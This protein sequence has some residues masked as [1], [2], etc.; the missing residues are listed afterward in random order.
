MNTCHILLVDDEEFVRDCI[1]TAL[2]RAGFHVTAVE[3]GTEA[4][5]ILE[6][7]HMGAS[8]FDLLITDMNMPRLTG[9]AL[10]DQLRTN[11]TEL[12]AVVISGLGD[13]YLH[14][15]TKSRKCVE[16]LSKPFCINE[17]I[18]CVTQTMAHATSNIDQ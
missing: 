5:A 11:G 8:S 15:E 13:E 12:P 18:E 1:A 17:L 2:C 14:A 4:L 6:K 16:L 7:D 3:N 9:L 10:I